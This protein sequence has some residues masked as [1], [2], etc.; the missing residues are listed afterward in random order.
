MAEKDATSLP[1]ESLI[2]S[3]A[4]KE[5]N[6]VAIYERVDFLRLSEFWLD[7]TETGIGDAMEQLHERDVPALL[8][9]V[10]SLQADL[11]RFE[12]GEWRQDYGWRFVDGVGSFHGYAKPFDVT[13]Q[14][15]GH[16]PREATV[17]DIWYGPPR[18]YVEVATDA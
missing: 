7:T 10:A 15:Q 5:I 2:S 9:L 13:P 17:R 4:G 8:D 16:T 11:A 18:P 3:P 1:A 6:L 14:R 12:G